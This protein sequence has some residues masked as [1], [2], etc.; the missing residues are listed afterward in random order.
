MARRRREIY[1]VSPDR[2]LMAA[3]WNARGEGAEASVPAP[4]FP[5][6]AHQVE[7]VLSYDVTPDGQRFLVNRTAKPTNPSPA[8][9][10]LDW[11]ADL[12]K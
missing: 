4:L 10:V 12:K 2:K 6:S 1:F 9:V 3:A 5:V 11:T 8:Y 7:Y